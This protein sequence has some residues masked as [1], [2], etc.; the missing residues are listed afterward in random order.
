MLCM[1]FEMGKYAEMSSE[2]APGPM[3]RGFAFLTQL[4]RLFPGLMI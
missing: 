2:G 1:Y 4:P 3:Y